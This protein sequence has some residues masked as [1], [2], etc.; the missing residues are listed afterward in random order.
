MRLTR[1]VGGG[2]HTSRKFDQRSHLLYLESVIGYNLLCSQLPSISSVTPPHPQSPSLPSVC[3]TIQTSIRNYFAYRSDLWVTVVSLEKVQLVSIEPLA[4]W[5]PSDWWGEESLV[6]ENPAL[7]S[8]GYNHQN[9]LQLESRQPNGRP[10]DI[11]CRLTDQVHVITARPL[12]VKFGMQHFPDSVRCGVG[13]VIP[14][15]G[16][17]ISW[18]VE[19]VVDVTELVSG[20]EFCVRAEVAFRSPGWQ[21]WKIEINSRHPPIP[22]ELCTANSGTI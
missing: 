1:A 7:L 15:A 16:A 10:S 19:I 8:W 2:R 13:S 22:S 21:S 6:E 3:H 11:V 18:T 17:S 14:T 9:C 5:Q 20:T 12:P 4:G